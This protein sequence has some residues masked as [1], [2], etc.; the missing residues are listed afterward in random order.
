[1]IGSKGGIGV[2]QQNRCRVLIWTGTKPSLDALSQIRPRCSSSS[3]CTSVATGGCRTTGA[4]G[5]CSPWEQCAVLSPAGTSARH[6]GARQWC[7]PCTIP[8]GKNLLLGC[9]PSM[10][11]CLQNR[12]HPIGPTTE[13]GAT[14]GLF[15]MQEPLLRFVPMGDSWSQSVQARHGINGAGIPPGSLR[16]P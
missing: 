14:R 16:T 1:M 15:L 2:H 10:L 13:A 12:T 11:Q 8:R 6:R 4:G 5:S 3:D 7:R 9:F